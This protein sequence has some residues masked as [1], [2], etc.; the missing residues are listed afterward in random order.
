M[1]KETKEK[2]NFVAPLLSKVISALSLSIK[3]YNSFLPEEE[4][5]TGGYLTILNSDNG[6]L[7]CVVA[8]GSIK[9]EKVAKY[10]DLSLEKAV[11][12]FRHPEHLASHESSNEEE[13]L[14]PGALRGLNFI[15]S[16]SGQQ[17]NIDEALSFEAITI[18]ERSDHRF[19]RVLRTYGEEVAPRNHLI[20]NLI[21]KI[22]KS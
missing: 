10:R 2:T 9:P 7:I 13:G 19:H 18:V 22:G 5:R 20:R 3:E 17:P 11:R 12:L 14:Y 16:F 15:V 6:D 21:S 8:L 1:T 4:R